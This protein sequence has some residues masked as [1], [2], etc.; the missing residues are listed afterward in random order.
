MRKKVYI[1]L[2]LLA[3]TLAACSERIG[4][5]HPEPVPS[6]DMTVRIA[7]DWQQMEKSSRL[8]AAFYTLDDTFYREYDL[9]PDG[10]EVTLPKGDYKVIVYN[11]DAT[12]ILFN[13]MQ[14][15]GTATAQI[16]P[17]KAG[18]KAPTL[19]LPSP[20]ILYTSTGNV[21]EQSLLLAAPL[22]ARGTNI[23][24]KIEVQGDISVD[25]ITATLRNIADAVNLSTGKAHHVAE[26]AM[27]LT[28]L[29]DKGSQDGFRIFGGAAFGCCQQEMCDA[30]GGH[31]VYAD[32]TVDLQDGTQ[33][34]LTADIT[35]PMEEAQEAVTQ[36]DIEIRIEN[37]IDGLKATVTKWTAGSASGDITQQ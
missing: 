30:P 37:I 17:T 7:P 16:A 8:K 19:E 36:I 26:D 14:Q 23:T 10:G 3:L 33:R 34:N 32:I 11:D 21:S 13:S 24:L 2:S 29:S 4:F 18:S 1:A 28:L 31:K 22:S 35:D 6:T 12:S 27:N 20:G 25:N 5:G 9:L 15:H